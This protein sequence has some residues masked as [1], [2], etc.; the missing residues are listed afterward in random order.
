[1]DCLYPLAV[2]GATE[3]DD[4]AVVQALRQREACQERLDEGLQRHR[5]KTCGLNFTDRPARGTPLQ[6]KV[7]AVL[8]YLS[9]LS[10][11]R[12]ASCWACPPPAS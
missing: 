12:T 5:C 9:G 11:N 2:Q 8:L 7:T 4:G 1:M 6:V 3:Q 10:M